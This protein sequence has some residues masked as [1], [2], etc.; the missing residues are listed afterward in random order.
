[1][2][3]AIM[4]HRRLLLFL[5]TLLAAVSA[6]C[7]KKPD[8]PAPPELKPIEY[9]RS[10]GFAGTKDRISVAADGSVQVGGFL[11]GNRRGK[12]SDKQRATLAEAFADWEA[13]Q[14]EYPPP[15]ETVDAFE[16]TITYDG[17][18]VM[19]TDATDDLPET[20]ERARKALEAIARSLPPVE[21]AGGGP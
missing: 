13:L 11:L 9:R 5:A 8:L 18:S 15:P 2:M 1:M 16:V 17:K 19:A 10:G 14:A 12:L 3:A 21:E 20:F 7:A 6:S 4:T